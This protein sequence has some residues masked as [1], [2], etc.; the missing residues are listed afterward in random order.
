MISKELFCNALN[1][2]KF[3]QEEI[4]QLESIQQDYIA[5]MFEQQYN[6]FYDT[7]SDLI[8]ESMKLPTNEV[9]GDSIRWWI[10]ETDCG[11]KEP[12]IMVENENFVLDTPEKL[13]DY[14]IEY[15]C[16]LEDLENIKENEIGGTYND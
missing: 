4:K 6:S 8:V 11:T 13:Y 16:E 3:R 15:E 1:L 10:Y 12:N 7:I 2:I 14:L 5:C 9:L